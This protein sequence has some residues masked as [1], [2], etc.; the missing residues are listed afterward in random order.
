LFV[1]TFHSRVL[2]IGLLVTALLI[3]AACAPATPTPISLQTRSASTTAEDAYEPEPAATSTA[4]AIPGA[5]TAPTANPDQPQRPR[6]PEVGALAYDFT[7]DTLNGDEMTLSDLRGKAVMI[8]FW[9]SWCG[10]CRV[11]IPHM[12]AAYDRY[13]DQG[14][15]ILAVNVRENQA[16][17]QDFADQLGM[18]FPIL[19]DTDGQVTAA[20]YVRAIPITF[21][22]DGDGVIRFIHQGAV[23]QDALRSYIERLLA[24]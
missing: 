22:V 16:Q 23:P 13:R 19:L 9:A 2:R 20:Y 21:F 8:N 7:L 1:P 6:L 5:S 11:E 14:F 4:T 17:V 15:E 18:T 3:V 12:I 10:P 24:P